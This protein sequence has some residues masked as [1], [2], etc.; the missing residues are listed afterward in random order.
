MS[1]CGSP[2][3]PWPSITVTYGTTTTASAAYA[4]TL[5][6]RTSRGHG[7]R[8]ATSSPAAGITMKATNA[9]YRWM[10][11]DIDSGAPGWSVGKAP[12]RKMV[13][14]QMPSSTVIRRSPPALASTSASS[15]APAAIAMSEAG[16]SQP[17]GE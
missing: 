12:T 7:V 14:A 3:G 15:P 9:A 4:V 1:P 5:I 2:T 6:P 17:C 11:P 8:S 10:P 16:S 13:P